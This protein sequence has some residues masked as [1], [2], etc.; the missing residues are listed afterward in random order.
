MMP[1]PEA[2]LERR[3]ATLLSGGTWLACLVIAVGLI[4]GTL[5]RSLG[6]PIATAGIALLIL[7]PVVRVAVMLIELL[8]GRDYRLAA[9][10][11]LVLAIMALG[12]VLG[13]HH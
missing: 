4:M 11:G 5:G 12:F 8:R 10:A 7:L 3:L 6:M 9:V 2:A 13:A 1:R